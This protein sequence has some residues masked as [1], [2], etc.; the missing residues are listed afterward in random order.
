MAEQNT[1]IEL[2]PPRIT[3]STFLLKVLAGGIGGSLGA[4]ILLVIFMLA[5]TVLT[6]ISGGQELEYVSP[7]FIFVLMVMVFVAS[8]ASN[9]LSVFLLSL[10]EKDKYTR[11]RSAI[12][13]VFIVSIIIFLMMVPLYL[14]AANLDVKIAAYIVALHIILTAQLSA[15]IL[16]IVSDYKYSLV[17]IYGVIFS[18]I[19]SAFLMT[20]V[21]GVIDY[22]ALVFFLALPIVWGSIAIFQSIFTM[23]YGWIARLYDKDFLSTQMVYGDDYGKQV[24][25]EPEAPKAVDEAGSDFLRHN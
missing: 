12:Y 6:P 24:V 11:T 13:Q 7:I 8:T 21:Y 5:A 15:I 4:L 20:I 9:L 19:V 16:E 3:F 22:T 17:G 23:L 10:T 14:L 2:G 1:Q 18:I 25:A